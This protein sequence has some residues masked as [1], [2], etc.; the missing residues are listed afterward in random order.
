ML[1]LQSGLNT[2]SIR[3]HFVIDFNDLTETAANTAQVI[4]L[5]S[6]KAGDAVIGCF[7]SAPTAFKD[8]SDAAF[9]DTAITIGD[10]G[11]AN[12]Y[13]ASQQLNE[14]GTEVLL[15]DG[16]RTAYMYLVDD[17]VDITFNSMTAK[18]LNDI[19][20]GKLHVWLEIEH[21]SEWIAN[22]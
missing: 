7:T 14:N 16:T 13:L 9:N 18:A 15:K 11:S 2:Q 21:R 1:H 10:G 3:H 19:D 6:L 12:R 17:T 8:A 20:T 22:A 5:I 4:N